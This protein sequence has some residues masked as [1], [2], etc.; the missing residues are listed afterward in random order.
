MPLPTPCNRLLLIAN[1]TSNFLKSCKENLLHSIIE[2][3]KISPHMC[4]YKKTNYLKTILLNHWS[5][6]KVLNSLVFQILTYNR[7]NRHEISFFFNKLK[8]TLI[9]KNAHKTKTFW[10]EWNRLLKAKVCF[11][12]I[13]IFSLYLSSFF[14]RI[15]NFF[16][17]KIFQLERKKGKFC[18]VYGEKAEFQLQNS[19]V[20]FRW[21]EVYFDWDLVCSVNC[22]K[23]FLNLLKYQWIN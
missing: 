6:Q 22:Q 17:Y 4:L 14:L 10:H 2:E 23:S 8:K 18:F 9:W 3:I 20:L 1:P 5:F 11:A 19:A 7:R 12:I 15:R 21:N 16:K 13:I